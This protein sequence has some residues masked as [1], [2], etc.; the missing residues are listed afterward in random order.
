MPDRLL[1][2]LTGQIDPRDLKEVWFGER[3]QIDLGAA[4]QQASETDR[5]AEFLQNLRPTHAGY[6]ALQQALAA[7][8][9]IATQGSWPIIVDGPKLRSED[10]GPRVAALKNRLL[11]TSDLDRT[12]ASVN[13]V[14]DAALERALQK[15]QGG[16]PLAA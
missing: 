2:A 12:A 11:L 10:R 16:M 4:L 7:Y 15:C 1:S 9:D 5:I 13:D 14:F 6:A 8:P 3:S